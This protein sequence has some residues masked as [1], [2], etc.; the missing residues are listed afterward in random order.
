[1]CVSDEL[2]RH[3]LLRDLRW[4]RWE[5]QSASPGLGLVYAKLPL[6]NQNVGTVHEI[7]FEFFSRK[8]KKTLSNTICDVTG[9]YLSTKHQAPKHPSAQTL[10]HQAPSLQ[11]CQHLLP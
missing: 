3:R 7:P 11:A 4:D 10:T 1:M 9:R 6:G 8:K 2:R 5:I